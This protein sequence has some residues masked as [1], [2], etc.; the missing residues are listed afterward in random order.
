M[1]QRH[2]FVKGA[3]HGFLADVVVRAA[4][5]SGCVCLLLPA[6]E[7]LNDGRY[8]LGVHVH[9]VQAHNAAAVDGLYGVAGFRDRQRVAQKG[10]ALAALED[11]FN[12]LFRIV[13]SLTSSC[14]TVCLS[15]LSSG[16]GI[17]RP[18]QPGYGHLSVRMSSKNA[19]EKQ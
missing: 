6:V 7:Y 1:R 5:F 16:A 14:L 19:A 13:A 11:D 18:A 9:K 12:A 15:G 4:R 8:V 17:T 3:A 10:K 2:G